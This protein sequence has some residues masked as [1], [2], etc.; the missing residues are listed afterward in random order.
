MDL[1][2]KIEVVNLSDVGLNRAQNEDS[3]ITDAGRGLLILADG[4][5]GR[6][7]GEI[8]S[9]LAVTEIYTEM[10]RELKRKNLER[11]D[12][13]TG[14][15][16]GSLLIKNA[17]IRAN[18][19]ILAT[20][21]A[22]SKCQGMG[23]TAVVGLLH[24]NIMSIAHVGD[25]R[26]YL[27]RNEELQ[28][29]TCDH[30][31]VQEEMDRGLSRE[32]ALKKVPG[33]LITRALGIDMDVLV[34]IV[35]RAVAPGDIFLLCSDGLNDMVD[36]KEIHLTLSKYSGNLVQAGEEL[37]R[38]AS[39]YGGKDNISIIL[40]RVRESFFEE[41]SVGLLSSFKEWFFIIFKRILVN[42]G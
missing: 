21:N 25:S 41:Q 20:A 31:L 28:Q 42:N 12:K 40:L 8:A 32:E 10:V 19:Q 29:I 13:K 37:V 7:A 14:F 38:L 18:A 6:E 23:T 16:Q 27:F 35:E 39:N 9:A 34:D 5:G 2:N 15:T 30:S 36:D 17:I 1:S 33:N 4:M 26:L 11:V 3:A 22:D 24:E